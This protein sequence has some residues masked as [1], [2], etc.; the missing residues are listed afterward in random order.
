[1][2]TIERGGDGFRVAA[3]D[4]DDP[5]DGSYSM[6]FGGRWNAPRSHPVVYLNAD[7]ETA[8]ANARRFLDDQLR[9]SPFTVEDLAPSELP[10]LITVISPAL[11]HL[12]V[13][14]P[15][16]CEANGLPETYP[17]DA[18][19][20]EVPHESCQPIGKQAWDGGLPGIACRSAAA[21]APPD[22][23]ELAWYDRHDPDLE[24]VGIETFEEWYG[25]IDW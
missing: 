3:P 24:L 19:G 14:T 22:G 21:G 18:L 12:D 8:R 6:R 23:E 5:L 1:M 20:N 25:P 11:E 4:W 16:G 9:G 10:L 17:L 7:R 13:V 2:E 15:G